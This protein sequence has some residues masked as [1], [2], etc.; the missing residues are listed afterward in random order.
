MQVENHG[1]EDFATLFEEASV[2]SADAA[3]TT[4]ALVAA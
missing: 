2:G 4:G 3:V 1:E